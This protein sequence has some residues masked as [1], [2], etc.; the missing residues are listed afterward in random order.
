[1]IVRGVG[2]M[3]GLAVIDGVPDGVPDAVDVVDD[4][5][6]G[7]DVVLPFVA[8][9]VG[10]IDEVGVADRLGLGAAAIENGDVLKVVSAV[11]TAT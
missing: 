2:V 11:M 5:G 8:L 1:M 6:D 4:V 7:V 9:G 10:V 3:L